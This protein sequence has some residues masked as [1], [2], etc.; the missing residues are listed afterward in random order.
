MKINF[1][2]TLLCGAPKGFM[3]AFVRDRGFFSN[4][5]LIHLAAIL[6]ENFIVRW[7]KVQPV[8]LLG[9]ENTSQED[10]HA[11]YTFWYFYSIGIFI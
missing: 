10:V 6:Y 3:K 11:F 8:P 7:S 2:F 5:L 1:I 4:I 9:D